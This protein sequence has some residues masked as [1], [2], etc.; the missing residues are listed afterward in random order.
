MFSSND[1]MRHIILCTLQEIGI[2]S[3]NVHQLIIQV[4]QAVCYMH[5]KNPVVAHYDLKP[6]NVLVCNTVIVNHCH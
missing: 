1:F 2:S 6:R 5:G 4:T 3:Y